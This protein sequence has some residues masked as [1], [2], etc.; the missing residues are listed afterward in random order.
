MAGRTRGCFPAGILPLLAA[1]DVAPLEAQAFRPSFQARDRNGRPDMSRFCGEPWTL[2]AHSDRHAR[3]YRAWLEHPS[4]DDYW[5]CCRPSSL[6][7]GMT[8]SSPPRSRTTSDYGQSRLIVGPRIHLSR[9]GEFGG[10]SYA[11][12]ARAEDLTRKHVR[13]FRTQPCGG[14]G[15]PSAPVRHGSDEWRGFDE[16]PPSDTVPTR[17]YLRSRGSANTA[18]GDGGLTREPPGMNRNTLMSTIRD[19]RFRALEAP[20]QPRTV[21]AP[22][23]KAQSKRVSTSCVTSI[24]LEPQQPQRT[25]VTVL[26]TRMLVSYLP[27][28][29]I[30]SA[31]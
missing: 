6:A 15:R 8:S 31:K 13:W 17:L 14:G 23:I 7:G 12:R 19:V 26:H 16:L 4:Y 22:S 29:T 27:L 10:R 11:P 18:A 25:R 1:G 28:P 9:T 3:Y 2:L 21:A 30:V 5:A 20:A 24:A